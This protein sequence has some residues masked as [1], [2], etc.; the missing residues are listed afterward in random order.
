LH[1]GQL[2]HA[3]ESHQIRRLEEAFAGTFLLRNRQNLKSSFG[4]EDLEVM[5]I[6]LGA[7]Q[8]LRRIVRKRKNSSFG[9]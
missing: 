1:P 6:F 2:Q 5:V 9:K 3:E 4:A 7:E 8:N